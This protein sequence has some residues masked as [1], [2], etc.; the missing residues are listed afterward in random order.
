MKMKSKG[1]VNTHRPAV[2][3]RSLGGKV[4]GDRRLRRMKTRAAIKTAALSQF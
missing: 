3:H 2:G 4:M 1:S